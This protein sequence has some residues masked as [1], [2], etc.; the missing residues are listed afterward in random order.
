MDQTV[1][2]VHG[3]SCHSADANYWLVAEAVALTARHCNIACCQAPVQLPLA[4]L[5]AVTASA[6][7]HLEVAKTLPAPVADEMQ[8]APFLPAAVS[9]G[10]MQ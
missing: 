10:T 8:S 1:C 7:A 5:S 2:G 6:W 3:D 4:S 9:A